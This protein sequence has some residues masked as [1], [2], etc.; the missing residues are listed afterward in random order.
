MSDAQEVMVGGPEPIAEVGPNGDRAGLRKELQQAI[1]AQ[2]PSLS[3]SAKT[4]FSNI[5]VRE[6]KS[7]ATSAISQA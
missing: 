7:E 2:T 5:N 6:N 4:A 3:L 1:S